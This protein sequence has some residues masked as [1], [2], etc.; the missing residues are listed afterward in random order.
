[1]TSAKNSLEIVTLRILRNLKRNWSSHTKPLS[2]ILHEACQIKRKY[3]SQNTKELTFCNLLFFL[4]GSGKG[5]AFGIS[6]LNSSARIPSQF[7]AP[8]LS[9]SSSLLSFSLL[10]LSSL[11]PLSGFTSLSVISSNKSYCW[12]CLYHP[13]VQVKRLLTSLCLSSGA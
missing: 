3:T 7:S 10:L 11:S 5:V 13:P 8:S 12:Y 9:L 6:L 2:L 1:M 4:W